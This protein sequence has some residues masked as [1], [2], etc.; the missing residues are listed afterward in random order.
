MKPTLLPS[1][2]AYLDLALKGDNGDVIPNTLIKCDYRSYDG[3]LA[4]LENVDGARQRPRAFSSAI[5][6]RRTISAPCILDTPPRSDQSY[7]E[8]WDRWQSQ[9]PVHLSESRPMAVLEMK[10]FIRFPPVNGVLNLRT[11]DLDTLPANLPPSV[12]TLQVENNNLRILPENLPD[13]LE[14]LDAAMNKLTCLPRKLPKSLLKLSVGS[15]ELIAL[16]VLPPRLEILDGAH[17]RLRQLPKLPDTLLTLTVQHNQLQTLPKLPDSLRLLVITDNEITHIPILPQLNCLSVD[18]SARD[19]TLRYWAEKI[20]LV[21]AA[22]ETPSASV[23]L[24]GRSPEELTQLENLPEELIAKILGKFE[25][26]SP[27]VSALASTSRTLYAAVH[28]AAVLNKEAAMTNRLC[29]AYD[30]DA[31][32]RQHWCFVG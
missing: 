4:G 14:I 5:P 16:P 19:A 20:R 26:G 2:L 31:I 8:E 13:G 23:Q 17:N 29:T 18:S 10:T 15:N 28:P 24:S 3:R 1:Q 22:V 32:L 21:E 11:L 12:K 7:Y 6:L 25:S 27:E 30:Q 9:S